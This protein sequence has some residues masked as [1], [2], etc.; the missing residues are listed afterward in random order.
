MNMRGDVGG[1]ID[2]PD[3]TAIRIGDRVVSH[4]DPD[5]ASALCDALVLGR[6]EVAAP[7]PF[8]ELP[9][10]RTLAQCRF[11]GSYRHHNY[12]QVRRHEYA[13]EI[14]FA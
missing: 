11:N 6:L 14:A 12:F 7:E 9:I 1:E 10:G 4:L 5:L 2:D 8:P 13:E 3:R